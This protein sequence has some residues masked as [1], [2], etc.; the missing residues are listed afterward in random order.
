MGNVGRHVLIFDEIAKRRGALDRIASTDG[1]WVTL[2]ASLDEARAV[3]RS[4]LHP[5]IVMV[6]LPLELA[7]DWDGAPLVDLVCDA[8][9]A[10]THAFIVIWGGSE[11]PNAEAR[12]RVERSGAGF[13]R[14]VRLPNVSLYI[15][16]ALQEAQRYLEG[17]RDD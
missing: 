5:L 9:F 17:P 15:S 7:S 14:W 16:H 10:A 8:D 6:C 11:E 13:V 12:E 2:A 1:H 3:L 4:A